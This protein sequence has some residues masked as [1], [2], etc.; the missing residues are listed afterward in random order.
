[1]R[2]ESDGGVLLAGYGS[3][4]TDSD[5][6]VVHINSDG[7]PDIAF[8]SNGEIITPITP[9]KDDVANDILIDQEGRL[10]VVGYTSTDISGQ[11]FALV[12]YE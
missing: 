8:A 5:F 1:M 12:R 4:G 9:G 2:V 10:V 6:T 11:D 7:T 3:N